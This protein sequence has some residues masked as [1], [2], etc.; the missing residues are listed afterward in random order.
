MRVHAKHGRERLLHLGGNVALGRHLP[1]QRRDRIA[2][3]QARDE[4]IERNGY[5][6]G[7][8]VEQNAADHVTHLAAPL[9]FYLAQVRG[10]A[11]AGTMTGWIGAASFTKG[12]GPENRLIGLSHIVRLL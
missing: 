6:D 3:G 10:T 11:R 1:Y 5:P 2:G 8:D 4:K 9:S 12:I 7:A